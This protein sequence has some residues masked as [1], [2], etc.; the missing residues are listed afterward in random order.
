MV[1]FCE[2]IGIEPMR[3]VEDER[4][5]KRIREEMATEKREREAKDR[6]GSFR[7][8]QGGP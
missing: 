3:N 4:L 8:I 5:R 6:R 7:V 2:R 1:A